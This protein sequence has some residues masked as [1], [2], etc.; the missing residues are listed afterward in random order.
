[1]I[2]VM[3]FYALYWAGFSSGKSLCLLLFL[4]YVSTPCIGQASPQ[5]LF[6]P[7]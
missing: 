4:P 6:A 7:I 5:G 3:G 2:T 1:L